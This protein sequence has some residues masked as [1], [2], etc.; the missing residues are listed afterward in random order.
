MNLINKIIEVKDEDSKNI[1]ELRFNVFSTGVNNDIISMGDIVYCSDKDISGVVISIN[2]SEISFEDDNDNIYTKDEDKLL[3]IKNRFS[4]GDYVYFLRNDKKIYAVITAI[5]YLPSVNNYYIAVHIEDNQEN[6]F[7]ILGN[8]TKWNP[9]VGE[10]VLI[11]YND[12]II[13]TTIKKIENDRIY[14]S[15]TDNV[16]IYYC[17]PFTQ[18]GSYNYLKSISTKRH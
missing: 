6:S 16:S 8:I 5:S 9:T 11:N 14:F 10:R 15:E 12:D 1:K 18:N 2:K 3:K 4:L 13:I 17:R 7:E